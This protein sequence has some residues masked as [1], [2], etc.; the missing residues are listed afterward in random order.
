VQV[1]RHPDPT[2]FRDLVAP[3]LATDEARHNLLLGLLGTM[4]ERPDVY[5]EFRLWTVREGDRLVGAALRTPPHNLVLAAPAAEGVLEAISEAVDAAGEEL[6]GV[7]AAQP[8]ADAFVAIRTRETGVRVRSR[9][10]QGIYALEEVAPVP[11]PP[12]AARDATLADLDVLVDWHRAF[13]EEASPEEH[14]DETELRR[15]LP[16]RLA[17][18]AFSG[19]RFWE[20]GEAVSLTGFGSPT[21][22]GVRIGPVYT[23]PALRGRGYA[24]ALVAEVSRECL[25]RGRRFCFLYT[26][27]SNPTSNAIYRRIGY[28]L[29]CASAMIRFG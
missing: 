11:V 16:A 10:E 29:H 17:G 19:F 9:M 18:P 2:A 21:P 3:F 26:D 28:R 6:P 8:E 13:F 20:D 1:V 23:P 4:V 25:R 14:F 15:R 12:G 5:P 24:S 7:V 27:M 22:T